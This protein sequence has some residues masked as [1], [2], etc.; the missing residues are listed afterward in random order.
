MVLK[1]SQGLI[2]AVGDHSIFDIDA[3]IGL[4]DTP[5]GSPVELEM[6]SK[7]INLRTSM[8]GFVWIDD[9]E[10]GDEG[11]DYIINPETKIV[12]FFDF[13]IF[14]FFLYY[15]IYTTYNLCKEFFKPSM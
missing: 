1:E 5:S 14:A 10:S 11:D 7:N 6:L 9:D 3:H 15:F 13:L 2:N 4:G 12:A 8:S